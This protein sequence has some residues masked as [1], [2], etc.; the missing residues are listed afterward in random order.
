[1]STE[2]IHIAWHGP[3]RI[4]SPHEA[5]DS[6][7]LKHRGVY[8]IYGGNPTYGGS[9]LLYIGLAV[10]QP[11]GKRI[12]QEWYWGDNRD[13]GN[14]EVYTGPLIGDKMPTREA[15]R[16]QVA[17]VERLLIYA[18][19][20]PYNSRMELGELEPELQQ[21]HVLNWGQHRDLMP[22]VSGLRWTSHHDG[23]SDDPFHCGD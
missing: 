21:V 5:E 9:S 13:S 11:I 23:L 3:V 19:R 15:W 7:G 18:H 14:I 8:Q 16:T 4:S 6:E 22:E 17:Q 10:D 20:P 12:K 1:M 2:L